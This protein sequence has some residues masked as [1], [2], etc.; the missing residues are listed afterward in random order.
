M[1]NT[2]NNHLFWNR[3]AY[4][5]S[6]NTRFSIDETEL[7]SMRPGLLFSWNFRPKSWIFII[8]LNDYR[9]QD[10]Q[11]LMQPQYSIGA[12]KAKYLLYF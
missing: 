12:I 11:G 10:D 6:T 2:F 1:Q 4:S 9:A 7:Y 5:L 8:A 3:F